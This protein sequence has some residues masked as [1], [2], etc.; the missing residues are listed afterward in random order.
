MTRGNGL[1]PAAIVVAVLLA[2][3]VAALAPPGAH[4]VTT[5]CGDVT[6]EQPFLRWLDPAYYVLAPDGGI[7]GAASQWTLLRGAVA[8]AGNEPF[9]VRSA[10]D[11]HALSIPEDASATSPPFCVG[12]ADPTLRF[13]YVNDGSWWSKLRVDVLYT[14]VFGWKRAVTIASL[15]SG[16]R[17]QVSPALPLFANITSLPL[18]PLGTTQI[19]LRFTVAGGDAWRIDDVYVDPF[20]GT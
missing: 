10:T 16:S 19:Q 5:S 8:V 14:D 13:F 4:G 1:R 15:Y 2:A 6:L 20:K 11:A 18:A 3:I 7:E 9:F 12:A 17:W